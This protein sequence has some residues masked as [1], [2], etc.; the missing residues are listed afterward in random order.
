M[1]D[2]LRDIGGIVTPGAAAPLTVAPPS[3][4]KTT[5]SFLKTGGAASDKFADQDKA[6][7]LIGSTVEGTNRGTASSVVTFV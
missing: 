5:S 3:I 2:L 1:T 4:P 6:V 7:A